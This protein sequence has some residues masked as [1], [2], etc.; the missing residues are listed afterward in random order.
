MSLFKRFSSILA[1]TLFSVSLS[2]KDPIYTGTFSDTAIG[3]Y[4]ATSYFLE[5]KGPL[6]GD[7]AHTFE[8][9]GAEWRFAS[10]ANLAKFK[11][12]PESYAPQYGGYCAWAIAQDK[13]AKGDPEVFAIV[14]GKLF[15]NYNEKIADRWET[16]RA[17]FIVQA[18]KNYSS[19]VDLSAPAEK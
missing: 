6:K 3:G 12:D 5:G 4:D 11:A 7:K 1:F 18:D 2:A 15:L 14:D 8:W 9:R 10:A 19:L 17:N 13:L 16:D